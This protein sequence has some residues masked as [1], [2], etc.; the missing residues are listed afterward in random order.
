MKIFCASDIHT[1]KVQRRFDPY[2]DYGSLIFDY[3]IDADVI[4]LAGD[5]GEWV[6]GL[7]WSANKFK[8]KKI[9]YVPGNHEYYNSDI[10]IIS[11]LRTKAYELGIY[12]L[13]N[14]EIIIDGVR[15]L[16]CTLWTDFDQYSPNIIADAW[17]AMNDFRYIKSRAWWLNPKN[18]AKSIWLM[19]PDSTYGMDLELF[20]PTVAYLVHKTSL[21]W[22]DQ[23]LN[24]TFEGKTVV[25][26]H[27]APTMKS[28]DNH[29]YGS[30]LD[31]F[32]EKNKNN[33]DLWCHGHIH[34]ALDYEIHGVRV[35]CNPRGYPTYSGICQG[36]NEAMI[37]L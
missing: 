10:S 12:L 22:L 34:K 35:V 33:I 27:H 26:S 6:N 37:F 24:E 36:F 11:E 21:Q 5:I 20:S 7:E 2:F 9:I 30:N 8:D 4:L 16:G 18:R 14:D 1:E 25:V 17:S 23:K 32:I 28:T 15:F 19:N 3:P 31:T 13:D 29:A